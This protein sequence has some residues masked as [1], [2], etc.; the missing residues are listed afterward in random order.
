MTA[1]TPAA[2]NTRLILLLSS[3]LLFA[4]LLPAQPADPHQ[5]VPV[6]RPPPNTNDKSLLTPPAGENQRLYGPNQASLIAPETARDLIEKFRAAYAQPNPPRLVVYVNRA[7]VDHDPGLRLASRTEKYHETTNGQKDAES[8]TTTEVSGENTYSVSD[9]PK[10]TLTDQQTVRDIERLFGRVFRHA[11]AALA[12]QKVAASLLAG[13]PGVRLGGNEAASERDALK[14][15]ADVAIEV[16]VSSRNLTVHGLSGDTTYNVPDIQATAIR[17]SDSAILGQA[18]ASDVL[19]AG[20]QAGQ[21]A[22]R[23]GA[24]DITEATAFALIEDMLT[25]K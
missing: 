11:G 1:K 23:F 6:N 2:M 8:A 9:T 14:Q 13:H 4:P 21:I 5:P 25:N 12:D 7:L 15:I 22:R 18:S 24:N 20:P 3:T 16:L 17:L 19:G 10:P